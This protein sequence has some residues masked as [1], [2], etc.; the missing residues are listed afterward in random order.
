MRAS[1][2]MFSVCTPNDQYE[3]MNSLQ[4]IPQI[5]TPQQQED[6]Q[7]TLTSQCFAIVTKTVNTTYH[8]SASISTKTTINDNTNSST[9]SREVRKSQSITVTTSIKEST[10]S[11]SC[12]NNVCTPRHNADIPLAS[13]KTCVSQK[14]TIVYSSGTG[15]IDDVSS[16]G[17]THNVPNMHSRI[18][19]N[20]E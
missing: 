6:T 8:T 18:Q 1:K 5:N 10:M 9:N 20:R 15:K 12:N 4:T 14:H 17:S 7:Q 11:L 19:K 16:T 2:T 13:Q 3:Q